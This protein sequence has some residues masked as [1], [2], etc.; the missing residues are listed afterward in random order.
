[1]AERKST[2]KIAATTALEE[3]PDPV[4][5]IIARAQLLQ[6]LYALALKGN[7]SAAK[8]YFDLAEKN[9]DDDDAITQD[10]AIKLI[11]EA[12]QAEHVAAA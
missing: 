9:L 4:D 5:K 10:Q 12:N 6:K 1:M 7:V 2:K 8:L 11:Q 3:N